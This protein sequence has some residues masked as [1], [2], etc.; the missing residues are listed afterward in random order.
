MAIETF[1]EFQPR[2][3]QWIEHETRDCRQPTLRGYAY[4]EEHKARAY[5]IPEKKSKKNKE[6]INK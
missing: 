3:C 2:I 1:N 6:L 4:C 5:Y